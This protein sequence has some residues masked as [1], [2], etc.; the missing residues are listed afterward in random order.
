VQ[1]PTPTKRLASLLVSALLLAGCAKPPAHNQGPPPDPEVE[2]SLPVTAQVTDYEDFPGRTEA[3]D[4]IDVRARVTGYLDKVHFQE[5]A[6]VKAGDL[7]FEIDPRPYQ[8]ELARA[9][10]NL[11]QA[12]AR[13]KRL[14]S[15]LTRASGL[16]GKGAIGREEFDKIA[17]DRAE[18]AAAV[19]VAT[20]SRDLG[21]LNLSF[22]Q[23]HARI[24]GRI[25]RRYIDPGN[26]AKADDTVLT[27]LV[28]L[29]PMYAYFDVDE[30]A[31]L[32]LQQLVRAKKLNLSPGANVPVLMGMA[33]ETA[34]S[35]KGTLHFV[36]NRVDADTGTWRLR[37]RF[38]NADHAIAS[39]MF[40]HIRL[41]IGE[42]Y[43]ALLIAE[44]ALGTDQGQRFVYVVDAQNK[45]QYRRVKI[46]RLHEGLRVI[47]DGLKPGEKVVVKGLQ[48]VRPGAAVK[49]T[50]VDT[51]TTSPGA[52]A[53]E[54]RDQKSEVRD[55]KSKVGRE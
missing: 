24:N 12:E 19:G 30:R 7:L 15:D 4:T 45:A 9:E 42:P 8:A 54:V 29:D 25:S 41:P 31:T 13:L 36:D 20:A 6:D 17:G 46:G 27:T 37:G 53:A 2:V 23:V 28:S 5:G 52:T 21:R 49:P 39:G 22:T 14:T 26:L 44:Q 51:A 3:V 16:I 1:P 55:Q 10:A 32:R 34:F 43:P 40:V 48:R 33:D 38:P 47:A 35:H 11:V 50:L 18:A